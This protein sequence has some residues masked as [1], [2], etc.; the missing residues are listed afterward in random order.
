MKGWLRQRRAVGLGGSALNEDSVERE[1][2]SEGLTNP[3]SAAGRRRVHF[4]SAI[5]SKRAGARGRRRADGRGGRGTV[6]REN[7]REPKRKQARDA[8]PLSFP[9]L[10]FFLSPFAPSA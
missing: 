5:G 10:A 6:G 7:D 9:F 4:I 3:P 8:A 2:K 1:Q